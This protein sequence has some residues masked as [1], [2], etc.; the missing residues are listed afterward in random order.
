M[1]SKIWPNDQSLQIWVNLDKLYVYKCIKEGKVVFLV[2]YVDDIPL[3]GNDVWNLS[4]AK[5]WLLQYFDMKDLGE[6]NYVLGIYL[7][8]DPKN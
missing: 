8:T 5:L 4:S 2:L 7:F 6:A 1:E 3:I